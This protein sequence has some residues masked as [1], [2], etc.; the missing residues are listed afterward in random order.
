MLTLALGAVK[1]SQSNGLLLPG[2]CFIL[3]SNPCTLRQC[4]LT[5]VGSSL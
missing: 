2:M 5:L 1:S 4:L 3:Y